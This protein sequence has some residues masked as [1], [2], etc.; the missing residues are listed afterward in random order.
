MIFNLI[1]RFFFEFYLLL[2]KVCLKLMAAPHS[3]RIG[4]R[5]I[6]PFHLFI[7]LPEL[8]PLQ[9]KMV[10]VRF[11]RYR[12]LFWTSWD[13]GFALDRPLLQQTMNLS[14]LRLDPHFAEI[15]GIQPSHTNE[16][17]VEAAVLLMQQVQL[18]QKHIEHPHWRRRQ[19][20]KKYFITAQA[21][22]DQNLSVEQNVFSFLASLMGFDKAEELFFVETQMQIYKGKWL[23]MEPWKLAPLLKNKPEIW[24]WWIA[25]FPYDWADAPKWTEIQKRILFAVARWEIFRGLMSDWK[26]MGFADE[27]KRLELFFEK[28]FAT[29]SSPEFWLIQDQL[30]AAQVILND[31]NNSIAL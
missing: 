7:F 29:E 3:I 27:F 8:S 1:T 21:D 16:A 19:Q 13:L 28:S 14:W 15:S 30:R 10:E 22:Q 9:R 17:R 5:E 31:K 18:D 25:Q 4:R 20:W 2:V 12:S 24:C 6:D 26:V 23:K 11:N